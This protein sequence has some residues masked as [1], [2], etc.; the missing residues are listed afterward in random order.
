MDALSYRMDV[1]PCFTRNYYH[2]KPKRW[3]VPNIEFGSQDSK[4]GIG[5]TLSKDSV[6]LV[7]GIGSVKELYP[8]QPWI[9]RLRN[10][11]MID[12]NV[13]L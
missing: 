4:A 7:I 5:E 3:K 11:A 2:S 9:T 13:F 8:R 12:F 10:K 6:H 1:G